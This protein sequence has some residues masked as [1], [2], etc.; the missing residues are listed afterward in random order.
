MGRWH[1]VRLA[2]L[3]FYEYLQIKRVSVP[4]LPSIAGLGELFEWSA[5]DCMRTAADALPL[6][7]H[8]Y[9]Y[10]MRGGFPQCAQVESV[11]AAQ[12]LLREDIV[13]KVLKRDMT[14]L[15]GVRRILELEQTFLYLC[16]HDGG[17]LDMVDLGKNLEVKKPTAVSYIHLLE[18]AQLIIQESC[19]YLDSLLNN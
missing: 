4:Q 3:S 18:A 11:V 12:K 9:D 7:G 6:T 15:H 19:P 2:T 14:A 8:F 16:L 1:T 5:T 17:L 13:D 10:L